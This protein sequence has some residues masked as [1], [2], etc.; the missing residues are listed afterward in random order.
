MNVE[1]P[2]TGCNILINSESFYNYSP[3]N[4]TR[5]TYAIYNGQAKLTSESY[6]QYGY[7]YT[8]TCLNTGDLVYKP[9]LRVEFTHIALA[10]LAAI[11]MLIFWMIRGRRETI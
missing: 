11:F 7:T 6:N 3:D 8:G 1:L 4:R 5:Q 9:E 10:V 2:T